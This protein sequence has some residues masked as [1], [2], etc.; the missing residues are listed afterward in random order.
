VGLARAAAAI[1]GAGVY[2][3]SGLMRAIVS[4]L[5]MDDMLLPHMSALSAPA[6]GDVTP[7][8]TDLCLRVSR[9]SM[10]IS[11]PISLQ[12]RGSGSMRGRQTI[13]CAS[14]PDRYVYPLHLFTQASATSPQLEYRV[15]L[16]RGKRGAA[17]T[18]GA[19]EGPAVTATG[20]SPHTPS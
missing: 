6:M 5:T 8:G 3:G 16:V 10:T 1:L 20:A 15:V 9:A 13:S 12:T 18:I 7:G 19:E 11:K 14:R 17:A 4:W 2:A